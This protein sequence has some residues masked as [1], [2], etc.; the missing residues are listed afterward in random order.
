MLKTTFI[1]YLFI[2]SAFSLHQCK[3]CINVNEEQEV[4]EK[5]PMAI[6][7]V[8]DMPSDKNTSKT[9]VKTFLKDLN[10]FTNGITS[11]NYSFGV[12]ICDPFIQIVG[13]EAVESAN[14]VNNQIQAKID[15]SRTNQIKLMTGLVESFSILQN[16]RHSDDSA[17]LFSLIYVGKRL[18]PT[19]WPVLNR[20]YRFISHVSDRVYFI[21]ISGNEEIKSD[22]D[23][24]NYEM[25]DLFD[26]LS[27]T[28]KF[29]VFYEK[30][31]GTEKKKSN[32][33]MSSFIRNK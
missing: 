3:A 9:R 11:G 30:E 2:L 21:N 13:L 28:A 14:D 8:L 10:A 6:Y 25:Y 12:S 20:L 24:N 1:R 33:F 7:N 16:F 32:I 23:N 27:I 5:V 15:K 29:E 18:N 31:Y 17:L 19:D 4:K 26:T 22:F